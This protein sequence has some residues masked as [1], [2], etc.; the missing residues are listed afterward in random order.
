MTS[1]GS[2]VIASLD[3][4]ISDLLSKNSKVCARLELNEGLDVD[5][6][7]FEFENET[8]LDME[9]VEY[10]SKKSQTLS[11]LTPFYSTHFI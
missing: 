1:N 10:G 6:D 3:G 4:V 7:E 8:E 9:T 11:S 2:R 5:V